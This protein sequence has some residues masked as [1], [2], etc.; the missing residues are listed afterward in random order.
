MIYVAMASGLSLIVIV[1]LALFGKIE[2]GTALFGSFLF[3]LYMVAMIESH[4]NL[5]KF[6]AGVVATLRAVGRNMKKVQENDNK[7]EE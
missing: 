6:N 4:K 2:I 3:L 5:K 1:W 7:E